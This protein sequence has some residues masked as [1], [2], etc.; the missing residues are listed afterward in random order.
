MARRLAYADF[1]RAFR[2]IRSWR[3][4]C[5]ALC[6]KKEVV[7]MEAY[8]LGGWGMYP[9][10]IVGAVL[11]VTALLYASRPVRDARQLVV[12]LSL[13]TMISGFLGTTMGFL[14]T[15]VAAAGSNLAQPVSA[16][17]LTGFGESL[18][19][20]VQALI[21]LFVAIAISGVGAVRLWRQAAA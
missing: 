17:L 10:T 16:L 21:F 18:Y 11:V 9:V 7:M 5:Y 19:C 20:V 3:A 15:M 8:R 2:M 6:R 4:P 1:D 14:H 13:L 12:C